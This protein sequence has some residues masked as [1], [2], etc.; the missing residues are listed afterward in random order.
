MIVLVSEGIHYFERMHLQR[1]YK[2]FIVRQGDD[3]KIMP[4][5]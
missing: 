2:P 3:M 1:R 5:V 4:T